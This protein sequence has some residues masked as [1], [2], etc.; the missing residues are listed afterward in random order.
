MA[1][2]YSYAFE[3]LSKGY[4][5]LKKI[6]QSLD[7]VEFLQD[8]KEKI[9]AFDIP[10]FLG[11]SFIERWENLNKVQDIIEYANKTFSTYKSTEEK[12]SISDLLS[13]QDLD[14]KVIN[15]AI[16]RYQQDLSFII[17]DL[18]L[19]TL[20]QA[21]ESGNEKFVTAMLQRDPG[22]IEN[23]D[24]DEWGPIH[25]CARVGNNKILKI[26]VETFKADVNQK[27]AYGKTP[28]HI[29]AENG[30][31]ETLLELKKLGADISIENRGDENVIDILRDHHIVIP[32]HLFQQIFEGSEDL[33]EDFSIT[34]SGDISFNGHQPIESH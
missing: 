29:A 25:A 18:S 4:E 26:L 17:N 15:I 2:N 7:K 21:I 8:V 13:K 20:F 16:N 19:E 22:L 30:K 5:E 3:N 23:V 12:E 28:M 32:R 34:V 27:T 10:K 24:V 33:S 9:C 31:I 6:V 11:S 14:I 1:K